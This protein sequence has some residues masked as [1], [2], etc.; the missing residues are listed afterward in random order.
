VAAEL[1]GLALG[2]APPRELHVLIGGL[3]EVLSRQSELGRPVGRVGHAAHGELYAAR[4]PA[5]AGVQ[6][7]PR[8]RQHHQLRLH[9]RGSA[10]KAPPKQQRQIGI[11]RQAVVVREWPCEAAHPSLREIAR[12]RA[13]LVQP[14]RGGEQEERQCEQE[15]QAE[16]R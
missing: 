15:E 5:R 14:A 7:L 1:L 9:A 3:R 16:Q 4:C 6:Q 12:E 8:V 13:Q 2:H 10:Q 11:E